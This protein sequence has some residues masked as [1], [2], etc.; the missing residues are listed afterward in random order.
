MCK[1]LNHFT[2]RRQWQTA[3]QTLGLVFDFV[4]ISTELKLSEPLLSVPLN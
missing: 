3:R 2:L 4:Q 1:F